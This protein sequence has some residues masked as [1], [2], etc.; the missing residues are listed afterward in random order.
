MTDESD[1]GH[2]LVDELIVR[3]SEGDQFTH[4]VPIDWPIEAWRILLEAKSA[5]WD[6]ESLHFWLA[7]HV[8][9]PDEIVR[10]L[11][12]SPFT[13]VRWRIAR[14]RNL[15]A[16]LFAFM[17]SDEDEGVRSSLA[18]NKKTPRDVLIMLNSDASESVRRVVKLRLSHE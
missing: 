3:N 4:H 2:A 17:A 1:R 15:P 16:D 5:K 6:I 18:E 9:A 7:G 11:A 10:T 13:R 14:K 8:N 12:S